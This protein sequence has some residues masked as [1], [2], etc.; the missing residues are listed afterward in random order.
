MV[1]DIRYVYIYI[2]TFTLYRAV[3][4]I[5]TH[6]YK[7]RYI[8]IYVCIQHIGIYQSYSGRPGH[9]YTDIHGV[10]CI[11]IYCFPGGD[12]IE[13]LLYFEHADIYND[14]LLFPWITYGPTSHPDSPDSSDNVY[15]PAQSPIALYDEANFILNI[16]FQTAPGYGNNPDNPLITLSSTVGDIA[17]VIFT[18]MITLIT[19]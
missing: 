14:V 8:Y 12:F 4:N 19:L 1:Y 9:I 6:I 16:T 10:I 17:H 11:Y 15:F 13:V 3:I 5:P 7:L 18:H 2:H